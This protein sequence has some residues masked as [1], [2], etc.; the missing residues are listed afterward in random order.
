M[1]WFLDELAANLVKEFHHTLTAADMEPGHV[2][3]LASAGAATTVANWVATDAPV[4]V[5]VSA[6]VTTHEA[7]V[8]VNVRAHGDPE[9]VA[10]LVREA[11]TQ[12]ASRN[13]L[14]GEIAALQYFRPGRPEPL[15]RYPSPQG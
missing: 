7:D 9:V 8:L 3:V 2:K 13:E 10:R 11:V 6:D 5:S 1:P 15:H 14:C 12:V 4:E